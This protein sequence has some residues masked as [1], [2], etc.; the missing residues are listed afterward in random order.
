MALHIFIKCK[1]TYFAIINFKI[2]E[3]ENSGFFRVHENRSMDGSRKS[4]RDTDELNG[5]KC[6]LDVYSGLKGAIL[7]YSIRADNGGHFAIWHFAKK[8]K[9]WNFT[10]KYSF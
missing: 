9:K 10:L 7:R 1:S 4:A 8:H 5:L 6:A 2:T 3:A